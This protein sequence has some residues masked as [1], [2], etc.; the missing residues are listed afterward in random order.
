LIKLCYWSFE[1]DTEETGGRL[2]FRKFPTDRIDTC[3]E[4][5]KRLTAKH[6][7]RNGGGDNSRLYLVATGGG[8]YKFYDQI[9]SALGVEVMREDEMECLIIGMSPLTLSKLNAETDWVSSVR[10]RLLH[11]PNSAGSLHLHRTRPFSLPPAWLPQAPIPPCQHWQRRVHDKSL[12]PTSIRAR[13]RNV[14]WRWHFM[15]SPIATNG[16]AQLRRD[17]AAR[18]KRG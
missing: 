16:C 17:A 6:R 13:R 11:L 2:N 14:S 9:K 10:P 4:F 18:R 5:M 8:A 15:E 12:R 3:I 7:M 1:Q